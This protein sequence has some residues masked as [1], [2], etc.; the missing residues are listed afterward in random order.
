MVTKYSASGW[1]L[2]TIQLSLSWKLGASLYSTYTPSLYYL[3]YS[4]VCLI[5]K[6]TSGKPVLQTTSLD[7]AWSFRK[8][9]GFPLLNIMQKRTYK[10]QRIQQLANLNS[11]LLILFHVEISRFLKVCILTWVFSFQKSKRRFSKVLQ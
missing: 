2:N 1:T 8:L 4:T 9:W 7:E 11:W 5:G 10:T 6:Y 3:Y